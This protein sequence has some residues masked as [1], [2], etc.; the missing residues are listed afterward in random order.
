MPTRSIDR[1]FCHPLRAHLLLLS[2]QN[3][4]HRDAIGAFSLCFN[5]FMIFVV[6]G[7]C[8]NLFMS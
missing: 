6:S 8:V 2:H 7:V 3:G 1:L 5:R 4:L